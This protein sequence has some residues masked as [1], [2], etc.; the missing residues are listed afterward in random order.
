MTTSAPVYAS[1]P[2][3]PAVSSLGFVDGFSAYDGAQHFGG[4]NFVRRD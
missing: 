1:E 4:E 2:E 3:D